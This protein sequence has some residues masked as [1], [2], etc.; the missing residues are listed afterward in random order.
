[1][2]ARE[3]AA[4]ACWGAS[5]R[6]R[7]GRVFYLNETLTLSPDDAPVH[8]YDLPDDVKVVTIQV[9]KTVAQGLVNDL[10]EE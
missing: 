5:L 2:P 4:S 3:L 8:E 6:K 9:E 10:T 7:A 1:M